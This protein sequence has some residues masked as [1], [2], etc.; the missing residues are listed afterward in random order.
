MEKSA[1]FHETTKKYACVCAN[2]TIVLR[3]KT[4]VNDIHSVNVIYGDPYEWKDKKWKASEQLME[5]IGETDVHQ[6]WEARI[7]IP[8]KRLRYGFELID[9]ENESAFYS[10]KGWI[11]K[12]QM[13]PSDCFCFPYIHS[14]EQHDSPE[15]VKK[16]VWYQLFLERFANGDELND[17]PG[18]LPWGSRRP[19]ANDF[20][21]GDLAGALQHM[22]H[23]VQLG[24][25]GIYLTPIFEATSNHKYDTIDY[26]SL[27]PAFG[28]TSTLKSFISACH[29]KGIRVMFDAVFNHSGILFAQF[30]D[31]LE[32]GNSSLYKDWFHFT[33]GS[34]QQSGQSLTY[35]TF[36]FVETMP[37]LNTKNHEVKT[38]LLD[39]AAYWT[40][41]FGIDGW[42][43]DVANEVDHAFWKAFRH[44]MRAINPDLYI[45]GE[46]WHDSSPWLD[47]DEFDGVMNYPFLSNALD[48]FARKSITPLQFTERMVSLQTMYPHTVT[49]HLLTL[50]GSHDTPR[51]KT[52]CGNDAAVARLVFTL[53][54][55]YPGTP[56]LYYGDEIGLTG[57]MDPDCRQCMEW[58]E[59]TWDRTLLDDIRMLIQL[60]NQESL[61]HNEG[62]LRWHRHNSLVCFSLEGTKE[63]IY[64]VL[65]PTEEQA[66]T[67][68]E[69]EGNWEDLLQNSAL[70]HKKNLQLALLPGER[71]VLKVS[72]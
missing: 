7:A 30:Q 11:D 38:Y 36:A 20:F 68:F 58:D 42:R 43:L 48:L 49:A 44:N 47:G 17:P 61:L 65:N 3:L 34:L 16:T 21:G 70:G 37:K 60:R 24:I 55:T 8:S 67:T 71:A 33:E 28:S 14:S 35:E 39:V 9:F 13:D 4:K 18:T 52:E 6:F 23:L 40:K 29:E 46:V 19:K 69:Q 50:V 62:Q 72:Q 10:E 66:M 63:T 64:V 12:C 32:K 5:L 56:C 59:E 22:D 2:E 25:T 31:V 27:D 45:L 26:K 41:E 57:G 51:I 53:L 1:V 54:F 15:W